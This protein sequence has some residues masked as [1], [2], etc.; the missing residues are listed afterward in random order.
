MEEVQG[1][2]DALTAENTQLRQK[3]DELSEQIADLTWHYYRQRDQPSIISVGDNLLQD[4][5]PHLLVDPTVRYRKDAQV[6]DLTEDIRGLS[7]G[8]DNIA[9]I[10]RAHDCDRTNPPDAV[11]I[12]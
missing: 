3:T 2:N 9:I 6:A 11:T 10:T 1:R 12:V 4:V 8:D 7:H 5:S